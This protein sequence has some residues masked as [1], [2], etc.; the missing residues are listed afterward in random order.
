MK[1]YNPTTPSRRFIT[2]PDYGRISREKPQ[3]SMLRRIKSHAG[4]NHHG[5]IT[6]RHQ[7][8]GNK[9]LY[10]E[11]DFKQN[12]IEIPGRVESLQYDPYRTAFIALVVYKDGERRYILAPNGLK[13]GDPVITGDNVSF[14]VGNRTLLNRIPVGTFVHNVEISPGKGGQLA[15][16]AGSSL[17]VLA[18]GNGYADLKMPSG[19]VR[20]ILWKSR[21][22]IGQVS[23]PE[24]N[25]IV[26]GKAGRSRW[27]GV[28]PTVRGKAMNPRDHKYGGGEGNTQ[29]GTKRPKDKWG[30]I[31]GGRKTRNKKK[32]S[33]KLIISRR[34]T[35]R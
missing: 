26:I 25:L 9:A 35:K 15:R 33:G 23:N 11:I 30:N 3:K 12:K 5:R 14:E 16:S 22:S 6:M 24:H 19:E 7:G 8:G 2:V 13:I 17:Q 18:N 34:K 31:T 21:A 28:R 1:K 10:R 27:L 32:W 29:R 20:K 4:R